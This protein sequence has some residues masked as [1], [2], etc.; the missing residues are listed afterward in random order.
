MREYI[1]RK[2]PKRSV[3]YGLTIPLHTDRIR[4]VDEFQRLLA[5]GEVYMIT[6]ILEGRDKSGLSSSSPALA[7]KGAVCP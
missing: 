1:E 3:R 4:L 5:T 2:D 7:G 6:T